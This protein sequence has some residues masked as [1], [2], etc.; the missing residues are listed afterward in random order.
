MILSGFG[1][2]LWVTIIAIVLP[3]LNM[4]CIMYGGDGP[5]ASVSVLSNIN[6]KGTTR[7]G[8]VKCGKRST[9]ERGQE[10]CNK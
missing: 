9:S 5:S 1:I 6:N 4:S 3:K 2:G 8:S 10:N 7:K